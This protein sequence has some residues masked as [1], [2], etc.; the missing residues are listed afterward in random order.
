VKDHSAATFERQLAESRALLG[1]RLDLYQIHSVTPDSPA[2]AN[3]NLRDKLAGLAAEGVSIGLTTSGPDQSAVVRAALAVLVDGDPLFTSV[4]CTYNVLETSAA[5]AL[6]EAHD[7]G[8]AVIVKEALANGRLAGGGFPSLDR[9]ADEMGLTPA[10]VALATV[11]HQPW[12]DIVLS[13]AVTRAQLVDNVGAS[14]VRLDTE[15]SAA[16]ATLAEPAP[17]YWQNRAL[18]P[19]R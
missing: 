13:G 17:V 12:A 18:L 7:A 14:A 10:A 19:W 6:A 5:A 3:R 8:C 15:R 16:L 9:F 4:Q 2:L 11:L 1:R